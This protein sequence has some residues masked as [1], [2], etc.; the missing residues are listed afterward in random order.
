MN[1]KAKLLA[2]SVVA[3]LLLIGCGGDDSLGVGGKSIDKKALKALNLKGAP[4][5]V[6]NAGQGDMSAIGD[7]EIVGGDLGFARNEA[8]ALARDEIAR[9]VSVSVKGS[10]LNA[11]SKT[12][13]DMGDASMQSIT[14]EITKQS[15]DTILSGTK[16]TD[17]WITD[18]GSRIFVLAKLD[19]GNKAKLEANVKKQIAQNR[20]IP[21]DMK[22][23]ML[24]NLD[25]SSSAE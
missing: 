13:S 12:K 3:A 1:T 5:W 2:G 19:E 7:A 14:E 24:E 22:R 23:E 20:L 10:L 15:T 4:N 17:T 16:Q 9:Q 25:L 18:D 21:N 6:L 11:K 8:L